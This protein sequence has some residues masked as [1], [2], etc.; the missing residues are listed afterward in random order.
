MADAEHLLN[1]GLAEGFAKKTQFGKVQ[2]GP[3]TFEQSTHLSPEGGIYIDQWLAHKA[4]GGQEIAQ[5]GGQTVTRVYAGGTI[6]EE[7]LRKLGLTRRVVIEELRKFILGSDGKTRQHEDYTAE[8][9]KW[10]YEYQVLKHIDDIPLTI[11]LEEIFFNRSRVF[12]HGF[13]LSPVE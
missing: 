12:A 9:G 10:L 4:S 11:G 6:K 7:E 13:L 3:F 2:R 1:T 5:E 8:D